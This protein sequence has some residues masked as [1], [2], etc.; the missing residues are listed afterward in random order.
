VPDRR[1]HRGPHPGDRE[2]FADERV[3]GLAAATSE[4]SWLL[5][6]AYADGASLKLVGDRHG[7]DAR[8]RTA[9]RRASCADTVL[10]ARRARRI[11][12]DGLQGRLWI[13]G[14]NV[15]TTVEAA[16]A[17]GVVLACRDGCW[18]DMASVHGSFRS[19]AETAPAVAAIGEF[20]AA[21]GATACTFLLDQPV[22]NSGRLRATVLA[23]AAERRWP[24]DVDVVP[25][26][27]RELARRTDAVISTADGPVLDRCGA[28]LDLARLVV[29]ARV[30]NAWLVDLATGS[31]EP[32]QLSR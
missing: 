20:L 1:R 28:W 26:P 18:R 30:P 12:P 11:D 6:R 7:L 24:W 8:Q 17:G 27:D 31:S 25:D 3:P 14:F 16:L 4:L 32:A 2:R 10:R 19:V 15:L 5:E 23:I 13:D 9:V 22:S 29:A 21:A